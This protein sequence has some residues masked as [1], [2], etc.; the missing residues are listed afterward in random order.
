MYFSAMRICSLK[1]VVEI[2][3]KSILHEAAVYISTQNYVSPT[4]FTLNK[5]NCRMEVDT[6][7]HVSL[8]TAPSTS[9]T[10]SLCKSSGLIIYVK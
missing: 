7:R 5:T 8:I 6:R 1:Y 10:S 3:H 9:R 2:R 4:K